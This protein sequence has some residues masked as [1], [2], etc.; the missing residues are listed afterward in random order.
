MYLRGLEQ[1]LV[2]PQEVILLKGWA[3]PVTCQLPALVALAKACETGQQRLLL[4]T[5]GR[6]AVLILKPPSLL[7]FS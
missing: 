4:V 2:R 5:E 1:C 3:Y 7:F 6:R